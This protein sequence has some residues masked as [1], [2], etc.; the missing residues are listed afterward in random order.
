MQRSFH[1]RWL[2]L[3][4]VAHLNLLLLRIHITKYIV[5][6]TSYNP[7]KPYILASIEM[8]SRRRCIDIRVDPQNWSWIGILV[9]ILAY[10]KKRIEL[11]LINATKKQKA[12]QIA[13]INKFKSSPPSPQ[14]LNPLRNSLILY[15]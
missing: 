9:P 2:P 15:Y 4:V 7:L 10:Q 1:A 5:I 12:K 3:D 6:I 14:Y 13:E 8:R 11:L